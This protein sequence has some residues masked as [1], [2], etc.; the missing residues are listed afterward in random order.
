M[1]VL[2]MH[3]VNVEPDPI[4]FNV[5][6]TRQHYSFFFFFF[7]VR[8]TDTRYAFLKFYFDKCK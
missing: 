4:G 5:G 6:L 8:R 2:V 1:R 3:A 7:L